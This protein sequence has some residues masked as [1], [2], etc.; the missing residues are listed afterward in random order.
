[1]DLYFKT[2]LVLIFIS[3]LYFNIVTSIIV[4]QEA[5]S[6]MSVRFYK[7]LFVWLIPVIGFLFALRFSRQVFDNDLHDKVIPSFLRKWIYDVTSYN[8][9][10]NRNDSLNGIHGTTS[11]NHGSRHKR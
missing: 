1:M 2:G 9:N 10:K 6:E 8:P 5:N 4:F 11:Y 3:L 7:L